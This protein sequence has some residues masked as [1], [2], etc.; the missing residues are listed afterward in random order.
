MKGRMAPKADSG[1]EGAEAREHGLHDRI[2]PRCIG[3][4]VAHGWYALGEPRARP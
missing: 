1:M 3:C 2:A 4:C